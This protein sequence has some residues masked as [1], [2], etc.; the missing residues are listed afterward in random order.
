MGESNDII[1]PMRKNVY[2]IIIAG[3]MLAITQQLKAQQ[4]I[5]LHCHNVFPEFISFLD[6]KGASMEETF[7]LPN[8]DI[9]VALVEHEEATVKRFFK[10]NGHFRLQPENDSMEPIILDE[11]EILGRVVGLKRYY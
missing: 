6:S 10:E 7:P 11:V 8:N 2:S 9:V 4:A 1:S 3:I 5:D